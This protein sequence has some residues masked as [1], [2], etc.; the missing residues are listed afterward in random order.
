MFEPILAL[1]AQVQAVLFYFGIIAV[2]LQTW[3]RM[4]PLR[5]LAGSRHSGHKRRKNATALG[6]STT[7]YS[8]LATL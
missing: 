3:E 2:A 8:L 6:L 4:P 5:P 1:P 7:Y